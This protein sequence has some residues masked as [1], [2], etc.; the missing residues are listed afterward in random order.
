M[1]TAERK[2]ELTAKGFYVED[3]GAE[4]GEDFAGEFRWMNDATGEFQ[5]DD[6]SDSADEAWAKAD[7]YE[8]A[9]RPWEVTPA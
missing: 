6:T 9:P 8:K 3:M 2:A 1:I 5:D 4:Y 7:K